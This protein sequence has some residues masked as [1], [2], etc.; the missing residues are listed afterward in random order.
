M[1]CGANDDSRSLWA[2]LVLLLQGPS[3]AEVR[4]FAQ[5]SSPTS[6]H[7]LSSVSVGKSPTL[8]LL[9]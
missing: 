6:V 3:L 9:D 2:V 7:Y 4:L 5:I 8:M 1:D